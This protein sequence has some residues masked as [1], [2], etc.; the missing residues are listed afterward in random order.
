MEM[1]RAPFEVSAILVMHIC[2]GCRKQPKMIT[3]SKSNM[4]GVIYYEVSNDL[5]RKI[6][7]AVDHCIVLPNSNKNKIFGSI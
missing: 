6:D 3:C 5:L 7:S 4:L 1:L 2:M